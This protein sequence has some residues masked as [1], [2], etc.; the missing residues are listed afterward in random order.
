MAIFPT[1]GP[2]APSRDKAPAEIRDHLTTFLAAEPTKTR[3]AERRDSPKKT[4]HARS[5]TAYNV[6]GHSRTVKPV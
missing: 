3:E 5:S 4:S 6:D 2:I 1:I